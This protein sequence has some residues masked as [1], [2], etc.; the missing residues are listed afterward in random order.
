MADDIR[1]KDDVVEDN[2]PA[3]TEATGC[4]LCLKYLSKYTCPRCNVKY[5]SLE[6]YKSRKHVQCSEMFYK[7]CVMETLQGDTVD[8][9]EKRKMMEILKRFEQEEKEQSL[10]EEELELGENLEE[11]LEGLDLDQDTEKIWEKL[12][13]EEK[14]E[15]QRAVDDGYIG[16]LV[17]TW[18]PWWISRDTRWVMMGKE[19]YN[20]TLVDAFVHWWIIKDTGIMDQPRDL[21]HKYMLSP[22]VPN[23]ST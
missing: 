10:G 15:F 7:Q 3:F 14:K 9:H 16:S 12:T 11:R 21:V 5:C 6:C 19:R 13:Q 2:I 22:S 8:N 23:A 20:K 17:D 18:V 1:L 4:Q